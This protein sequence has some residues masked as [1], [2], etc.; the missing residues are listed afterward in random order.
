MHSN[1]ITVVHNKKD[2]KFL[3]IPSTEI[4]DKNPKPTLENPQS[5]SKPHKA[6]VVLKPSVGLNPTKIYQSQPVQIPVPAS[7]GKKRKNRSRRKKQQPI[8]L[9]QDCI[10]EI[11]SIPI[12][13]IIPI[14]PVTDSSHYE[15]KDYDHFVFDITQIKECFRDRDDQLEIIYSLYKTVNELYIKIPNPEIYQ[16]NSDYSE[17]YSSLK[18]ISYVINDGTVNEINRILKSINQQKK[19]LFGETDQYIDLFERSCE[20]S[21]DTGYYMANSYGYE[22]TGYGFS[23]PCCGAKS[24][25]VHM[26]QNICFY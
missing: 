22:P 25:G 9:H 21:C 7:K 3:S 23:T 10:S 6:S 16:L 26:S 1:T 4:V 2:K 19:K 12:I 24:S 5:P 14:K 18:T 8:T 20:R 11:P 15:K 17:F 13:P